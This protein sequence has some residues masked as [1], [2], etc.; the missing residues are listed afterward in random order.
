MAYKCLLYYTIHWR[1]EGGQGGLNW[2]AH[3]LKLV[4]VYGKLEV[5]DQQDV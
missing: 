3:P 5:A 2:L 4:K 1:I